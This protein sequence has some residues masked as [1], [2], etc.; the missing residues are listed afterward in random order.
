MEELLKNLI[1]VILVLIPFIFSGLSSRNVSIK[2]GRNGIEGFILGF[3]LL[4]FGLCI[5]YLL[6]TKNNYK[7]KFSKLKEFFLD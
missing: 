5:V 4:F 1:G 6:P 3:F 2:K 7:P